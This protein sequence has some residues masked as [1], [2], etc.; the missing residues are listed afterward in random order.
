MKIYPKVVLKFDFKLRVVFLFVFSP[1][2]PP[3]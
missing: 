1:G 3:T 2:I